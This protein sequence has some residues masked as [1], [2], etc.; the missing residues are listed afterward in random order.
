[1]FHIADENTSFALDKYHEYVDYCNQGIT[2]L[3]QKLYDKAID[4]FSKARTLEPTAS[5]AYYLRAAVY[6]ITKRYDEAISDYTTLIELYPNSALAY[7]NRLVAYSASNQFEKALYDCKKTIQLLEKQYYTNKEKSA[8]YTNHADFFYKIGQLGKAIENYKQAIMLNP[9][10][11]SNYSRCADAYLKQGNIYQALSYYIDAL[12][13]KPDYE[14]CKTSL[15]KIMVYFYCQEQMV[16]VIN[17]ELPPDQAIRLLTDML[18]HTTFLGNLFKERNK[19]NSTDDDIKI[20]IHNARGQR[21]QETNRFDLAIADYNEVIKLAPN[22][23]YYYSK[24]AHAYK[25]QGQLYKAWS[26]YNT[27]LKLSPT[28]QYKNEL[29]SIFDGLYQ[30]SFLERIIILD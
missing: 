17:S 27:A 6:T 1:M 23:A 29:R 22:D 21:Y 25:Q 28:M 2:Y 18:D 16:M 20:L 13:I 7:N 11:G 19:N 8:C 15:S 24:R 10:H 14:R 5:R 9:N 4:C 3:N 26:D 30:K 12:R